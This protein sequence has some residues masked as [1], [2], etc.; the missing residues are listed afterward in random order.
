MLWSNLIHLGYNL[1]L[2]RED[3]H[4]DAL[5]ARNAPA[6]YF[7]WKPYAR[8]D[9]GV[10]NAVVD[11]TAA[12]G[13]N[14]LVIAPA[15]GVVYDSHPEIATPGAWSVSRLREELARLRELGIEP[16]PKLNFG[17]G[18]DVW[19]GEYSRM[20]SSRTYY[21]VVGDLIEEVA[22]IFGTPDLFHIGMDEETYEHQALL[23]LVVIRQGELWWHDLELIADKVRATGA[24]PWM[25]ADAAWRKAG[26]YFDRMST[27]VVQSN[28]YYNNV[29][30]GDES[31]RPKVVDHAENTAY[32]TYL[33]LDERG[34]DQIPTASTFYEEENLLA[35]VRFAKER[36]THDKVLGFLHSTWL[37]LLPA[38]L[39]VHLAAIAELAQAR[40]LWEGTAK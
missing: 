6:D 19:M 40:Q 10:W 9:D 1:N 28:W 21:E 13:L 22:D 2:D 26:E 5:A 20:V 31:G 18:H 24:R 30:T 27:D 36:L 8:I 17:A 11:A 4:E 7:R 37:P 15:D 12:A 3:V 34:F 39:D 32:L 14:S 25:W 16:Q 23:D 38:H 29:F 35:T 33:D